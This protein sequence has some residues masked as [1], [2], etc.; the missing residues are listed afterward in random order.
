MS[1]KDGKCAVTHLFVTAGA[2]GTIL[3]DLVTDT[4][5]EHYLTT[6]I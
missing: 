6:S 3:P 4:V 1:D 2:V 5:T